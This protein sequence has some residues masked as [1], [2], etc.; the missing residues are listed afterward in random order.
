MQKQNLTEAHIRES[1][2]GEEDPGASLDVVRAMLQRSQSPARQPT[3]TIHIDLTEGNQVIAAEVGWP[4]AGTKTT[5]DLLGLVV[6]H[7]GQI[8]NTAW[9]W[10][11]RTGQRRMEL[12][13]D[14]DIDGVFYISRKDC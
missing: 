5:A 6:A 8:A 2:A 9:S 7:H 10:F 13:V 11:N 4:P 3:P 12:E 14:E 1:I